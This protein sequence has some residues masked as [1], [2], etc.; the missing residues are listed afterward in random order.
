MTNHDAPPRYFLFERSKSAF[1]FILKNFC[2]VTS[3]PTT[4]VLILIISHVNHKWHVVTKIFYLVKLS[5]RV[6][7]PVLK[8]Y[9]NHSFWVKSADFFPFVC[10]LWC[11]KYTEITHFKSN[12]LTHGSR[13]D[14]I[15]WKLKI[16][17]REKLKFE[18]QVLGQSLSQKCPYWHFTKRAP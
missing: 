11:S 9:R 18:T 2:K 4:C 16:L 14:E 15:L 7:P 12:Q 8:I 6:Y 10:I 5:I 17:C 1:L 3:L 13:N